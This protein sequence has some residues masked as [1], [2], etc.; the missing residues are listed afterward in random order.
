[1]YATFSEAERHYQRMIAIQPNSPSVLRAYGSYLIDIA[2]DKKKG[3]ELL[4]R[5]DTLE[6][7]QSAQLNEDDSTVSLSMFDDLNCLFFASTSPESLG[8][9]MKT[10]PVCT[11]T[12]GYAPSELIGSNVSI[13]MPEPFSSIHRSFLQKYLQGNSTVMSTTRLLPALQK[14]GFVF[15]VKITLKETSGQDF[16]LSSGIVL[17]GIIRALNNMDEECFVVNGENGVVT[18][19][20]SGCCKLFDAPK[21]KLG[22]TI[23]A[24]D[25]L[26]EWNSLAEKAHK[27]ERVSVALNR[28]LVLKNGKDSTHSPESLDEFTIDHIKI[29]K[30]VYRGG[31]AYFVF[32]YPKLKTTCTE[33]SPHHLSNVPPT[34]HRNSEKETTLAT[35]DQSAAKATE[36]NSTQV[37]NRGALNADHVIG[38]DDVGKSR[39]GLIIDVQANTEQISPLIESRAKPS[40]VP[41]NRTESDQIQNG[42]LSGQPSQIPRLNQPLIVQTVDHVSAEDSMLSNNH[43]ENTIAYFRNTVQKVHPQV[44]SFLCYRDCAKYCL[45]NSNSIIMIN[46]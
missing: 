46:L 14:S 44:F 25:W 34:I 42:S 24:K 1:M 43:A 16:G 30:T 21:P 7:N 11:S 26:P 6:E 9:I 20:S 27:K 36:P 4:D 39:A 23:Y 35:G 37:M 8:I 3:I 29:S 32:V 15:P 5:A 33:S 28:E 18:G 22:V 17:V 31:C 12:F 2:N 13:L 19:W 38:T 40:V 45:Y 41:V 10:N